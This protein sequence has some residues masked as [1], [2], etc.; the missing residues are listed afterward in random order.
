MT[1][2]RVMDSVG[3]WAG[4][5]A[6]IAALAGGMPGAARADDRL[7]IVSWGGAY[8]KSQMLAYIRPYARKT[9]VDVEVL[10]YSGGL[11]EI[12]AQVRSLN[13]KWDVVDL[14]LSDAL[15]GCREGLL[16]QLESDALAPGAD[17]SSPREDF[18]PGSLRECAVGS[19]VWSTAIAYNAD[20][21]DEEIPRTLEDFFDAERFPVPRAMRKTPKANLEWALIVDG[22][23]PEQVYQVLATDSGLDRAFNVLDRIKPYIRWWEAGGD[24]AHMLETGAVDMA[25][26]YTGRVHE[27]V[28]DRGAP[29]HIVW[30]HQIW[31]IDLWGIPRGTLRAERALDFIRFATSTERLADQ[32]RH[33]PYGPVRYS[34]LRRVPADIRE[35]LPTQADNF[36]T[37]LQLDAAWWSR[38]HYRINRRFNQWLERPVQFPQALPR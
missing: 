23:A 12:R 19:V 36:A 38:N 16:M 15:R 5:G 10:D 4:I 22:V 18:I 33:I 34:S 3:R 28:T 37:A 32:A 9:G 2:G 26:A 13:V 27:A 29:L 7:T 14:E 24:A 17:G 30:D 11:E 20:A 1:T 25:T 21:F 31:N 35:H 6:V 8:T